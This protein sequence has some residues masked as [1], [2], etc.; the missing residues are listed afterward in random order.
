MV[1]CFPDVFGHLF[2]GRVG[3]GVGWVVAIA[4]VFTVGEDLG[5]FE[6][7]LLAFVQAVLCWGL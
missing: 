7:D 6:F 5:E 4:A 3:G 1:E 2:L